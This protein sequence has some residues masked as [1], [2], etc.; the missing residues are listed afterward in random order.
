[1]QR[2]LDLQANHKKSTNERA[3][4]PLHTPYIC[5]SAAR[6]CDID[7]GLASASNLLD[8]SLDMALES[9]HAD[10]FCGFDIM[11]ENSTSR[12]TSLRRLNQNP[13]LSR[14]YGWKSLAKHTQE[15]FAAALWLFQNLLPTLNRCKSPQ[16]RNGVH[17]RSNLL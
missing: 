8:F 10:Y 15:S 4:Y 14:A 17:Q 2:S 9:L 11:V 3:S 7:W 16:L 12:Q 13:P 1:M 6:G 5:Q